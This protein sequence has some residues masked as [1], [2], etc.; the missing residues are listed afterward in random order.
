[1]KKFFTA[2]IY[3]FAFFFSLLSASAQPVLNYTS[4]VTGLDFPVDVIGA[5]EGN[6]HLFIVQ[7]NGIVKYYNGTTTSTFI[8]LSGLVTFSDERGLLSMAFHP[9]FNGTTNR[10]F[11]V[12][13]TTTAASITTVRIARYQTQI[14]NPDVGDPS[15]PDQVIAIA[16]PSGQT[17]HNGGKLNFGIDGMLYFG[18]GDG[19]SGNDPFNNAQDGTTLLGK[20]LRI[21]INGTALGFYSIPSDNPYAS[22]ADGIRDEIWALGLRNPFRWSFDPVTNAVWIG[23]VGQDQ[24]EE[25]DVRT[26]SPTTGNVNYGWRCYEGNLQPPPGITACSPLPSNYVAPIFTYPHNSTTGGFAITG[27]YVYRGSAYPNLYGYYVFA[28]YVSGNVWVMTQAGVVTQQTTDLANVAGFGEDNNHELYALS[29]GGSAGAGILYRVGANFA[30]PQSLISFTVRN[31]GDYNELR[32]STAYEQNADKYIIEFSA[33]GINYTV[34]GEVPAVNT[35]SEHGYIYRHSIVD[36][37]KRFYRLKM[38]DLDGSFHYSSVITIGGKNNGSVT[39]Y[40]TVLQNYMLSLNANTA[41]ESLKLY[42]A[43]GREL[44]SN[45]LNGRQGYFSIQLPNVAKGMYFVTIQGRDYKTT[46]RI[47]IQ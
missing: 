46:E 28:D 9:G 30:L 44:Y 20:M 19:G 35:Q 11:F 12:Y 13:Y 36:T 24:Q 42:D 7:Q 32:W 10:Y 29:R 4:T 17:N 18:T 1:M 33:D 6:G 8:D 40:P 2:A 45:N 22:G 39:I 38:F 31:M 27:G 3:S 14:G 5:P 37:R 47:I 25:V 23:D 34:A 43:G 15:A 26:P 21:D 16:K 41:V